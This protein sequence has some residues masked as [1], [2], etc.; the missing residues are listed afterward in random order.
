MA[1]WA[2]RSAQAIGLVRRGQQMFH[3]IDGLAF[4]DACLERVADDFLQF[5][6]FK[7]QVVCRGLA[8]RSHQVV[9]DALFVG[10]QPVLLAQLL[11][12]A[13]AFIVGFV[14]GRLQPAQGVFGND[15]A[16]S[17]DDAAGAVPAAT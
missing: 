14:Q 6:D 13:H 11:G 7:L 8:A 4:V 5:L 15:V 2:H 12:Q 3:R 16:L 10:H 17:V 1:Q 9:G